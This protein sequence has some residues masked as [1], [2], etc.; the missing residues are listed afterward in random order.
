M[1]FC[2]RA[3]DAVPAKVRAGT[4]SRAAFLCAVAVFAAACGTSGAGGSAPAPDTG[5]GARGPLPDVVLIQDPG[6][7]PEGVEWDGER[8]RFLVSSVARGSITAV[9]DDGSHETFVPGQGVTS[10]IG[11]HIDDARNRLLVVAADFAAVRDPNVR[12]EA[13]LAIYDLGSGEQIDLVD[14]AAVRPQG[15]HLANDLTVDPEGIVYVTDS[16]SPVIYQVTPD[17]TASV[18]VEDSRLGGGGV[19]LNGIEYH[20]DGYLLV[21]VQSA[22]ELYRIPLDTPGSLTQVRLSEPIAGD[23]LFLRPDG[24]LVVADPFHPG[25]LEL[26]TDDGW[27]SAR[28]GGRTRTAPELST[29]TTTLRDGAV[30]ALNAHFQDKGGVQPVPA[31]EIFRADLSE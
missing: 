19:S 8:A 26:I 3:G 10:S 29:T 20:P 22:R 28:I 5:T 17:G 7:Y 25:V 27:E 24:S 11:I 1:E 14:L 30:Y 18:L 4:P 31:F 13:K 9:H 6:L 23:G 21:A 12:G 16:F 2:R 15:R